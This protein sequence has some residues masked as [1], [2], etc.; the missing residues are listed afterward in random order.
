M[1]GLVIR[2]LYF[3]IDIPLIFDALTYFWYANDLTVLRQFPEMRVLNNGWPTF[4]SLFFFVNNSN[5]YFDFMN[6]QRVLTICI[7]VLTVVPIYLLCRKFFDKSFSL[8][9]ASFFILEPRII[10]NSLLGVTDTLYLLLYVISLVLFFSSDNR[11]IYAS[12]GIVALCSLVRS[13]GLFLFIAF[14]ILYFIRFRRE[15]KLVI[16]KYFLVLIIFVLIILPMAIVRIETMG[17]DGLFTRALGIIKKSTLILN[18]EG[19]AG[20]DRSLNFAMG[21]ENLVKFIGWTLI[22]F[23]IIFVPLGALQIFRK[24]N[25]EN[26]TIIVTYF[27]MLIPALYAYSVPALDTRYMLVL[28][29]LYC[30]C[31]IFTIKFITEKFKIRKNLLLILIFGCIIVFSIIFLEIKIVEVEHEREAIELAN[32][33]S[34]VVGEGTIYRYGQ[35]AGFL[36][37][38]GFTKLQTFPILKQDY[39][40]FAPN[41]LRA[42]GLNFDSMEEYIEF[43]K[44]HGLTHLVLDGKDLEPEPFID[45]FNNEKKYPYLI[46][47]FDSKDLDYSYHLKIFKIDYEKFVLVLKGSN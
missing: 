7:S 39:E 46:K 44:K 38:Q 5:N 30:I 42:T 20:Y 35:E 22:P 34:S 16:P 37:V 3:H 45:A 32:Y 15:K 14:S 9:G 17:D 43:G 19:G 23:Y 31:S 36:D 28:Y 41:V 2:L 12:F 18:E 11:K 21:F 40:R 47:E 8:L 10:Q 4:L 29:P 6:L 1:I 13:E 25:F 24:R 27:V 26:L 33:I